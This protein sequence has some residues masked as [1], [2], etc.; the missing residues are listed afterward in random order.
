MEFLAIRL[1]W[2]LLRF[3]ANLK[4]FLCVAP[5]EQT[6]DAE[7]I[8]DVCSILWIPENGISPKQ[9]TTS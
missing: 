5:S 4:V 9:G 6:V 2:Q 3:C 8:I 1:K 7:T